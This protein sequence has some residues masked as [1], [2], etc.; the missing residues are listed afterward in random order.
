MCCPRGHRKTYYSLSGS[1]T[2]MTRMFVDAHFF[3]KWA[4][5]GDVAMNRWNISNHGMIAREENNSVENFSQNTFKRVLK[6]FKTEVLGK[7]T[8]RPT[9]TCVGLLETLDLC[10]KVAKEPLLLPQ[11]DKANLD[12]DSRINV[13]PIRFRE[14]A[15][16]TRQ[17]A[18]KLTGCIW[19]SQP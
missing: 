10:T 3:M 17:G 19:V 6:A 12:T 14:K 5:C 11:L 2:V 16:W 1:V 18:V 9:V 7:Y 13:K 8:L 15:I 4:L